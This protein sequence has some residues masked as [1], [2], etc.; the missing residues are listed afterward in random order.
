M[1][2][3]LD[4][5]EGHL[6]GL[7]TDDCVTWPFARCG[8]RYGH[9]QADK[10]YHLAHRY[11]CESAHGPAPEGKSLALHSCHNGE[12]G[13]VNPRHLRWGSAADNTADMKNAGRFPIG[14]AANKSQL[15]D[16]AVR[17]IRTLRSIGKRAEDLA[18]AFGVSAS[19]IYQ[20]CRKA[21]WAH[22]A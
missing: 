22:V 18:E 3:T 7:E 8:G 9:F 2:K 10:V 14:A 13:C 19:A 16:D 11:V 6:M 5:I 21:S 15:T 20:I 17:E 1:A 12:S 4:W